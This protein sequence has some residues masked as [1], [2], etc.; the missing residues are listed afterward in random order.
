MTG[1]SKGWVRASTAL[2]SSY[3]AESSLLRDLEKTDESNRGKL[4]RALVRAGFK[5]SRNNANAASAQAAQTGDGHG[6]S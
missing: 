1:E 3:E 4:L 2:D 6:Q 5:A